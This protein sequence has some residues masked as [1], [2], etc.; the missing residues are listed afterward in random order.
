MLTALSNLS[1]I[2][3]D[4]IKKSKVAEDL[5]STRSMLVETIIPSLELTLA[6]ADDVTV[7]RELKS[8]LEFLYKSMKLSGGAGFKTVVNGL[9]S[10][11]KEMNDNIPDLQDAIESVLPEY[12]T[13]TTTTAKM[14]GV[15]GTV[16]NFNSM[17]M[18][19]MDLNLY[20]LYKATDEN[21]YYKKKSDDIKLMVPT[22]ASNY[23]RYAGEIKDTIKS[24]D[25]LS[26]AEI[27]DPDSFHMSASRNDSNFNL[28][29][30]GFIG[31][32][33]YYIRLWMVDIDL[34]KLD[35]LRD[36]KKLVELKLLDLKATSEGKPNPKIQKQIEYYEDKLA[37]L[38]RK[39]ATLQE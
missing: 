6:S 28:P 17:T 24:I 35:I 15:L 5:V 27:G 33:I 4:N 1:L 30:N 8:T 13:D 12:I 14:T 37:G 38:E 31:N 25:K 26:D 23:R 20:I 36:K 32:P 22:F 18:F 29:T 10:I 7:G 19:L 21:M 16:S 39:I 34:N 11:S 3:G 9:L 2:F